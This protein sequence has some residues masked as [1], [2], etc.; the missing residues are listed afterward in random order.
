MIGGGILSY[1]DKVPT[2]DLAIF[3]IFLINKN[4]QELSL[5]ELLGN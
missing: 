2:K 4:P 5:F 3:S 1:F